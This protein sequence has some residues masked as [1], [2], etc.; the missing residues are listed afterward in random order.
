MSLNVNRLKASSK[1]EMIQGI[2]SN[3]GNGYFEDDRIVYYAYKSFQH[4][5]L[6]Y[7]PEDDILPNY[8]SRYTFGFFNED[9][10][11]N[12]IKL[13]IR[14]LLPTGRYIINIDVDF[15]SSEE[16]SIQY[17]YCSVNR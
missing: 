4:L 16:H 9:P 3:S 7:K 13:E 17:W 14:N 2:W 8:F 6:S 10:V 11:E 15:E 12:E 5:V 1:Y